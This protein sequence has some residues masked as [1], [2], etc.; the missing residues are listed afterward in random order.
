MLPLNAGPHCRRET[1]ISPPA[2]GPFHIVV[3]PLMEDHWDRAFLHEAFH[4]CQRSG[5]F[6]MLNKNSFEPGT[7]TASMARIPESK[8]DVWCGRSS[9]SAHAQS[10]A[11]FPSMARLRSWWAPLTCAMLRPSDETLPVSCS[12]P[13]GISCVRRRRTCSGAPLSGV[14]TDSPT[15]G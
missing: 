8:E 3:T 6:M 14:P 15:D 7:I 13:Y 11:D 10:P 1:D 4:V 5:L 12:S 2:A 9:I